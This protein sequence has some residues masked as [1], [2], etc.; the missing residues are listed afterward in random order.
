VKNSKRD[1]QSEKM[2]VTLRSSVR[3]VRTS[4]DVGAYVSV[5][6]II[7]YSHSICLRHF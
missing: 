5:P 2:K 3:L 7:E 6:M 1:A 4:P